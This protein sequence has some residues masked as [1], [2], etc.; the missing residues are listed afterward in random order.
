MGA[1]VIGANELSLLSL[2]V[3]GLIRCANVTQIF[4]NKE[5]LVTKK[6]LA[7]TIMPLW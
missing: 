4:R 7:P 5:I 1:L 2:F 3:F 6:V